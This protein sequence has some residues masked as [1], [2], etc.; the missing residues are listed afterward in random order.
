MLDTIDGINHEV[1]KA[2]VSVTNSHQ[3]PCLQCLTTMHG[4]IAPLG[5]NLRRPRHATYNRRTHFNG[6]KPLQSKSK[7]REKGAEE[8]TAE[9]AAV[10]GGGGEGSRSETTADNEAMGAADTLS[11]VDAMNRNRTAAASDHYLDPSNKLTLSERFQKMKEAKVSTRQYVCVCVC[12]VC[13]CVCVYIV[14]FC[15]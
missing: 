10:E 1:D 8:A 12:I 11:P 9:T 15:V 14:C 13:V 7:Q 2:N 6:L 3:C 5:S 4:C